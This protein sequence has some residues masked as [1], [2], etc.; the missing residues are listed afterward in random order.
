MRC[1]GN[2]P[3]KN[4]AWR[5]WHCEK[6][7]SSLFVGQHRGMVIARFESPE[8]VPDMGLFHKTRYRIV[9]GLLVAIG[10]AVSA[11]G[12]LA[13]TSIKFT[14]DGK[15]EGPVAP[16]VVAVDKG[17]FKN[18]GLEVSIDAALGTPESI[19]RVA[20]GNYDMGF[21]D[22]NA[23]M[24]YRDEN[25]GAPVRAVFMVYNKPPFAIIGRKS[26]GVVKPKDL[27]GHKLGAPSADAAYAKWPIFAQA[28]GIDPAKVTIVNVAVPVREPMLAS[29]E[30]DAISGLSFSSALDLKQRG[31]PPDDI[32]VLLM[33][34]YGVELYGSAVLVNSKFAADKPEAVTAFLRGLVNGINETARNPFAAVESVIR[35]N[36]TAARAL[37]LERLGMALQDNILTP[38][39]KVNGYGSIDNARFERA[40]DQLALAHSF[41]TRPKAS[42]VFEP[43]FLP[44]AAERALD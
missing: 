34:D 3:R 44:D 16:F 31:V 26:R 23:L 6:Q 36:D 13:Q 43:S 20:S 12:A 37:E 33:A 18:Q 1:C 14:L 30:V 8:S 35:R 27:E 9:T 17:Y 28:S 42:D 11:G 21:A 7:L 39:V 40:I 29:G 38:E 41:K 5:C 19:G 15:F 25:P 32:N 2:L 22:I 24:K 10:A 4:S